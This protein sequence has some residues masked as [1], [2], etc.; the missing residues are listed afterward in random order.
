MTRGG[1]VARAALSRREGDGVVAAEADGPV[2]ID[3]ARHHDLYGRGW[4]VWWRRFVLLAFA[5]V[6]LLAL[7]D[8]FGQHASP[9]SYQSPAAS[10]QVDSPV[11]LR[12]GLVFTTDIVVT[13]RLPL[14]DMRLH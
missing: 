3:R 7:L 6:P 9:V 8:V 4:H 13:P 11:H 1:S 10:L 12:G 2:G 14:K 5:V